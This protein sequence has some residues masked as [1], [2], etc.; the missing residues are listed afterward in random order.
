MIDTPASIRLLLPGDI[1]EADA[2]LGLAF[3]SPPNRSTD[4][5][6]YLKMQ[7]ENWFSMERQKRLVGTV[8]ALRY[9]S[10][11]HVG[12]MAV[13]PECQRQGIGKALMIHLLAVLAQKGA[14]HVTLDASPAGRGLYEKLGFSACGDTVSFTLSGHAPAPGFPPGV[15]PVLAEDLDELGRWDAGYFGA[16]RG[17]LFR[18]LLAYPGRAFLLRSRQGRLQGYLFA[19]PAR[20]GPWV[21][22]DPAGAE[23]LLNAALTLP[24]TGGGI[25][26][27]L[28]GANAG[29]QELVQRYGFKQG[30]ITLHMIKA[31]GPV[32]ERRDLIYAQTSLA[33]G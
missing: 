27:A 1:P 16:D 30:Q 13:H 19:Q 10:R 17:S 4:L 9:G 31:P 11:A 5:G 15:G 3:D 29:A 25:I 23:A 7:P 18:G 2:L 12:F 6:L 20:I 26:S 22:L 24:Y 33:A 14:T 32:L 28:S 8:G 21:A